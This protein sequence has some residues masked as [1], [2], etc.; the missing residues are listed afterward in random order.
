MARGRSFHY[1]SRSRSH[2]GQ[3]SRS[4]S[5]SERAR[6]AVAAAD[7]ELRNDHQESHPTYDTQLLF[8]QFTTFPVFEALKYHVD[9][10]TVI[11]SHRIQ[12]QGDHLFSHMQFDRSENANASLK[13]LHVVANS[14]FQDITKSLADS[15]N[16]N[17]ALLDRTLA[18]KVARE[19]CAVRAGN[20]DGYSTGCL[21]LKIL[22]AVWS[23][24]Q[25]S[26]ST[27]AI[28]LYQDDQVLPRLE[29]W[30]VQGLE[31]P[32]FFE[33][34]MAATAAK[35]V[36]RLLDNISEKSEIPGE[37]FWTRIVHGALGDFNLEERLPPPGPRVFPRVAP[38]RSTIPRMWN[39]RPIQEREIALKSKID[40]VNTL[41]PLFAEF[42]GLRVVLRRLE[43]VVRE[44]Q[45]KSTTATTEQSPS[46]NTIRTMTGTLL[47]DL[48][49]IFAQLDWLERLTRD[50]ISRVRREDP[51]R[52]VE[53]KC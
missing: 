39:R 34:F 5:E 4:H 21:D 2:S 28:L 46:S 51:F 8:S 40:R 16:M 45:T 48:R 24:H 43:M 19:P 11:D 49:E 42:E 35:S 27:R 22:K 1:N 6:Q 31:Q 33:S 12:V 50:E 7:L 52:L 44:L 18:E 3:C 36:Q 23:H 47:G 13:I 25:P 14:D 26:H 37:D 9:E 10:E 38:G 20:I 32:L 53:C 15:L 29:E 17:V 30:D 41:G